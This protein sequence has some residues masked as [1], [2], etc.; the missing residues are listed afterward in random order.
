MIPLS[1]KGKK[2]PVSHPANTTADMRDRSLTGAHLA[3]MDCRAGNNIPS[4]K[5]EEEKR[6]I[7]IG[8]SEN[9][10]HIL[11]HLIANGYDG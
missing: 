5:P 3:S 8:M 7:I 4:E 2:V 11:C 1:T 6:T 10:H 9:H